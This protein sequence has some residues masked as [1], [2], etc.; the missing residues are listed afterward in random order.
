MIGL[1]GGRHGSVPMLTPDEVVGRLTRPSPP[2]VLDVRTRASYNHDG[3]RIPGSIRV[4]PDAAI[5]W[6]LDCVP[7]QELVTYCSSLNDATSIRVAQ[8]LRDLG[9]ITFVLSEGIEAWRKDYPLEFV[10]VAV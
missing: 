1:F 10:E 2:L 3:T 8:Q 7:A 9:F 5:E 4:L 6:A